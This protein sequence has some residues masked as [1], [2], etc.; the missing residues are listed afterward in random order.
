MNDLAPR[1]SED[2]LEYQIQRLQDLIMELMDCCENRK[3]H[4][5]GKFNL[6]YAE[7]RCLRLFRGERYLTVKG[8]AQKLGV[9]KSRVTKLINGLFEKR[10]VNRID[11][12]EDARIRLISLSGKGKVVADEIEGFEQAIFREMLIQID[13]QERKTVLDSLETL[14]SAMEAVK[15]GFFT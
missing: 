1:V 11:D 6:P 8:I 7:L 3:I 2:L 10:L 14:R 4:E 12:P 13:T 9:A 15:D 5:T